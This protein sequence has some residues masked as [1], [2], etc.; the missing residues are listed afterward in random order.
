MH[1][2]NTLAPGVHTFDA[3]QRFLGLELGARM[4]V[5]QLRDGL[6]V[7][8]P[9]GV[10]PSVLEHLGTP[11]WVLAPNLFHHLYI[12]PWIDAGL[13]G[14]GAPG[15]PDKRSDVQF[16][17]VVS[18]G[19]SPFG[20]EVETYVL[21][22][23]S[24]TNEVLLLHKRSRTLLVSDLVFNISASAPWMTRVAMRCLGGY[25]GC[26]V[27]LLERVA[28]RRDL[29]REDLAKIANWDFD[30][31]VMAHGDVIETG[32]KQALLRA[33]RWL[34]LPALPEAGNRAPAQP[35]PKRGAP[36]DEEP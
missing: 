18:S 23:F 8:S 17:G 16:E 28:M 33:F 32:G 36:H 1:S 30:R 15:L 10:S 13:D 20:D 6:L 5:L 12:G 21:R 7:H 3:T 27:T 19:T 14:W 9:I 31:V 26:A 24:M 2:L 22:C 29:A 34:S 11:R 4:T 35:C 25:P